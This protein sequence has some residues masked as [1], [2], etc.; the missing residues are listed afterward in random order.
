MDI[1]LG[2]FRRGEV[3]PRESKWADSAERNVA[4]WVVDGVDLLGQP[5]IYTLICEEPSK[6][7][8][9]ASRR[10]FGVSDFLFAPITD[11]PLQPA[12]KS[13]VMDVHDTG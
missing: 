5:G 1:G 6:T 3:L 10:Y 11:Y 8:R 2:G 13:P 12:P 7:S 4:G 9:T